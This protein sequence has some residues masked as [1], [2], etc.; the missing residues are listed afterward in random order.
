MR[1]VALERDT[2]SACSGAFDLFYQTDKAKGSPVGSVV[3]VHGLCEH[4]GRYTHVANAFVDAGFN[5]LLFDLPG[6]GH[7]TG[8]RGHV[9]L[10]EQY[11]DAT[12]VAVDKACRIFEQKQVLLFGHS[13]GG[14]IA[15]HYAASFHENLSGLILSNPLCREKVKIPA[16]QRALIHLFSLVRPTVL[17]P[18]DI[19]SQHLTHDAEMI[20]AHE[21]D[22]LYMSHVSARCLLQ[23]Q[24]AMRRCD[25]QLVGKI[26]VPVLLQLASKDKIVDV[27]QARHL[28]ANHPVT[29]SKTL[30]Y[31]DFYHEIYNE[32][33]RYQ[34]IEHVITW[35][36]DRA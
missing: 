35:M 19:P 34:P 9:D 23:L 10:F 36:K 11:I 32:V 5:V 26:G 4:S 21:Q 29:G 33:D 28:F 13:L 15:L 27:A 6:H 20:Q 14:L 16:W 1:D 17:F 24:E 2:F 31:E 18:V 22:P 25:D 12:Q 8:A 3:L 30:M 7:S